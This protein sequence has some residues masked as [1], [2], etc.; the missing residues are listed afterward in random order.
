[1]YPIIKI[2][3]KFINLIIEE[4]YDLITQFT[5]SYISF[6]FFNYY[7]PESKNI[8]NSKILDEFKQILKNKKLENITLANHIT[9]TNKNMNTNL[10]DNYDYYDYV[11]YD[12]SF[13]DK[14]WTLISIFKK[15]K[16][17]SKLYKR[18]MILDNL[19]KNL[20]DVNKIYKVG[21]LNYSTE[22]VKNKKIVPF[23][24]DKNHVMVFTN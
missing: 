9:Y 7:I 19:L 12:K 18:K 22:L 8:Y 17:M 1:M 5:Y 3:L 6:D 15:H 20:F 14:I 4:N 16:V 11:H 21:R 13:A 23:E 2:A 24:V 10:D